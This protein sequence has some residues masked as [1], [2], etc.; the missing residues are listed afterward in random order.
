MQ[1]HRPG[2][3]NSLALAKALRVFTW[4]FFSMCFLS[5]VIVKVVGVS[6]LLKKC[7]Y[8]IMGSNDMGAQ[9][10]ASFRVP[11]LSNVR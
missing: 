6:Q 3:E 1:G 2:Q 10:L 7:K 8:E 9:P 5:S 4:R 11:Y